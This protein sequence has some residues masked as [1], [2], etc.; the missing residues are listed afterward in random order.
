MNTCYECGAVEQLHD[1][2]VVPKSLGGTKTLPLCPNC[3]GLV[4]ERDFM[5]QSTLQ[6]KG[7]LRAK[8]EGR[9]KGRQKGTFESAEKFLA[10]PQNAYVLALL[11][12]QYSDSQT[13]K[14]VQ[15]HHNTVLKVRRVAEALQLL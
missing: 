13:A 4:H 12:L 3:H 9:Y 15:V 5:K 6:K 11:R 7:V 10:K 1:H 8:A 14:E 2:H